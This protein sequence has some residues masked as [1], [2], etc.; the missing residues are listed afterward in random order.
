MPSTDALKLHWSRSL[1]IIWMWNKTIRNDIDMPGR[2]FICTYTKYNSQ[3]FDICSFFLIK[4]H[5]FGWSR[6]PDGKLEE[7][8]NQT[9]A[10]ERIQFVLKECKCKTGCTSKRCKCKKSEC[11]CGPGCQCL[12]CLNTSTHEEN[13]DLDEEHPMVVDSQERTA[14][15]PMITRKRETMIWR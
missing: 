14:G 6:Q 9:K 7:S 2:E 3:L 12:N 5:A 15:S 13:K 10:K 4:L 8:E 1:W 11:M